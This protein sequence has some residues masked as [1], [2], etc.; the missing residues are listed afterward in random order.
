MNPTV[1][2]GPTRGP[3][4]RNVRPPAVP[5]EDRP[6]PERASEGS[7]PRRGRRPVLRGRTF[8]YLLPAPV[9]ADH[10]LSVLLGGFAL[11]GG[12][13]VYQFL[14]RGN[15]VQGPLEY[16]ATLATTILGFYLM[17]LGLREWHAFYPKP[18]KR[19]AAA[20]KR[21]WPWFG[22]ALWI[23][24]TGMTGAL[25]VSLGGGGAGAAPFWIAWP[26]GGVVV[27]AFGDFFFGLRKEAQRLGS[28]L[29]NALA[30]TAFIW[31][32]GVAT[33]AGRVVGDLSV[34]LLTEFVTSWVAL[35]ASVGPIVVAMS[36]LFVTYALMISA[37]WPVL[38]AP[39]DGARYSAV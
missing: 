12:T 34:Q 9:S 35:I 17:F 8:R 5:E 37:F 11:E 26:V 6:R 38:R 36:P 20:S 15:L 39:G 16:Y 2:G 23:A 1:E 18:M 19:I 27:L 4:M 32:L 3:E 10:A 33:I 21:P 25:S 22:L 14:A 31:S 28:P 29:G 30:W 13:E 24:G 7:D